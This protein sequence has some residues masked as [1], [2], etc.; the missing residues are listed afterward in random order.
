MTG[1]SRWRQANSGCDIGDDAQLFGVVHPPSIGG[2]LARFLVLR[3]Q[4]TTMM[5][6][7]RPQA[8]PALADGDALQLGDG[9]KSRAAHLQ[10]APMSAGRA[11]HHN[12]PPAL[13]PLLAS[14]PL[15]E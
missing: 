11:A 3:G 9:R 12:P 15:P 1:R 13:A 2:R 8:W 4:L 10:L 7:P 6:S 5:I 14:T